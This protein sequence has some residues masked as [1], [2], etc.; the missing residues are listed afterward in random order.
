MAENISPE[1]RLFNV[2]Q[3]GKQANPEPEEPGVKKAG[4]W[5]AALKRLVPRPGK[6]S[7]EAKK[8][9]DWKK[10]FP[11]T[12]KF[13]EPDAAVINKILALVLLVS[14]IVFVFSVSSRHENAAKIAEAVSKIQ[15]S[16]ALGAKKVEPFKDL[17]YYLGEMQARDIFHPAPRAALPGPRR[18]T[19]ESF[20]KSAETLK[21]VG[22]S[23]SDTPKAMV[24]SQEEK[25]G[26]MYFVTQGQAIGSTGIKVKEIHRN[27]VIIGDGKEEMELL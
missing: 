5:M 11:A 2:I 19:S 17:G 6:P 20:K 22:I 10:I 14:V 24:L 15:A 26:K 1:E 9:F 21:L 13:P 3:R 27:K 16:S 4:G 18:E 23:W 8:A 12:I 7:G 25:D